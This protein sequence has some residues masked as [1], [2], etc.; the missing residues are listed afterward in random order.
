VSITINEVVLVRRDGTWFVL[1]L[2]EWAFL[3][4]GYGIFLLQASGAVCYVLVGFRWM[5]GKFGLIEVVF[6]VLG[7]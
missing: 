6:W 5:V 3:D 1:A 4:E 2:R 7:S